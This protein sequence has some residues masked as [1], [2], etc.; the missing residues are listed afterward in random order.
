MIGPIIVF[1]AVIGIFATFLTVLRYLLTE[2]EKASRAMAP[3][4]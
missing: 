4:H 1:V 2:G 3:G